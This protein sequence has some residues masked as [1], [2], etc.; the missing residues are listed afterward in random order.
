[1]C[2]KHITQAC[3]L[4]L[5]RCCSA[6]NTSWTLVAP[7]TLKTGKLFAAAAAA[8]VEASKNTAG[9]CAAHDAQPNSDD[10][11]FVAPGLLRELASLHCCTA[12]QPCQRRCCCT[13]EYALSINCVFKAACN[14]LDGKLF[15]GLQVASRAAAAVEAP[16]CTSDVVVSAGHCKVNTMMPAL[17]SAGCDQR[18]NS[19]LLVKAAIAAASA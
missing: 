12:D 10:G 3:F 13:P 19:T 5:L 15:I 8:A 16:N 17:L 4:L 14:L 18:S 9:T 7:E 2:L 11:Q 6:R 1:M